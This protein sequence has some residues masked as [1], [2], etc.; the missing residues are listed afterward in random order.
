MEDYPTHPKIILTVRGLGY[1]V[2]DQ[3]EKV[4]D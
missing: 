3:S 4:T 2:S 1:K